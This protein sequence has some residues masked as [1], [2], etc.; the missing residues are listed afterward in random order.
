M[1]LGTMKASA[2]NVDLEVHISMDSEQELIYRF[3]LEA[4]AASPIDL[5][6]GK[7]RKQLK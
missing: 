4:V 2:H 1:C 5:L 7:H 3:V 6:V